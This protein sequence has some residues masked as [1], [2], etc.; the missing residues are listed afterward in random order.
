MPSRR[1]LEVGQHHAGTEHHRVVGGLAA[2]ELL[3]VLAAG[4]IDGQA[5]ALGGRTAGG[6][7]GGALLAQHVDGLVDFGIGRPSSV[8]RST[9]AAG[10]IAERDLGIDLE[11]R[12]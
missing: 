10:H 7:V 1:I 4:E 5:I 8:A 3:A 12:P 9:L 6:N 11:D 2:L